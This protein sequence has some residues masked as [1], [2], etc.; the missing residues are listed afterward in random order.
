MYNCICISYI[1]AAHGHVLIFPGFNIGMFQTVQGIESLTDYL[2]I[3]S[4][5]KMANRFCGYA[6]PYR[7]CVYFP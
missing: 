5:S 7:L 3:C 6:A 4:T 1:S 2:E